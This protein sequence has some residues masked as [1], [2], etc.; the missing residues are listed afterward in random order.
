[1]GLEI[2]NVSVRFGGLAA[3][4]EVSLSAAEGRSPD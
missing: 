2:E 4:F 1:M 3:L